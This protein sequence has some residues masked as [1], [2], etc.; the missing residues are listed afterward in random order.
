MIL[1]I[2][3]LAVLAVLAFS[4][5]L[6]IHNLNHAVPPE[7]D[8]ESVIDQVMDRLARKTI[9]SANID[10]DETGIHIFASAYEPN[11]PEANKDIT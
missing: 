9:G 8:V 7:V 5:M 4:I 10:F 2:I 3:T 6:G 1:E 11:D